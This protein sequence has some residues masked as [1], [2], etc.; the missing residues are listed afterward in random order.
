LGAQEQQEGAAAALVA[1][2]AGARGVK[3]SIEM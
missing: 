3:G 2:L 1:L